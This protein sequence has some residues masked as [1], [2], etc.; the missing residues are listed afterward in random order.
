MLFDFLTDTKLATPVGAYFSNL[1]EDVLNERQ[2][3]TSSSIS[4]SEA[5]IQNIDANAAID[6]S[7]EEEHEIAVEENTSD[8]AIAR[9]ATSRQTAKSSRVIDSIVSPILMSGSNDGFKQ[10]PASFSTASYTKKRPKHR[11]S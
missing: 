4:G 7:A 3:V 1:S 11:K 5:S 6:N 9:I 10:L 8:V 2:A